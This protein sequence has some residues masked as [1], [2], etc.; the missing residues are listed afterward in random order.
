MFNPSLSSSSVRYLDQN[1]TVY[2]SEGHLERYVR[3]LK[4][5]RLSL[6]A[7]NPRL[8]V[9]GDI[10]RQEAASLAKRVGE[11]IPFRN[12]PERHLPQQR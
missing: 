12:V 5:L 8:I 6:L 10:T 4:L 1:Q 3:S 9:L 2:K 11:L 7:S